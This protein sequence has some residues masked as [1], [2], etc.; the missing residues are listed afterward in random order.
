M[1]LSNKVQIMLIIAILFNLIFST[2]NYAL[3]TIV[4]ENQ[5]IISPILLIVAIVLFIIELFLPTFGIAGILSLL[6]F[7]GFFYL[8][9]KM[10]NADLLHIIIF[11]VGC[12][13][14][15]IEIFLPSFG[16]VGLSGI[17]LIVLGVFLASSDI[18]SGIVTLSIAVIVSTLLLFVFIKQGYKTRLFDSIIL[19][20]SKPEVKK[21]DEVPK[22]LVGME[23]VALTLLRPSGVMKIGDKRIDVV[24]RG[25]F[26]NEGE[27]L[28]IISVHGNIVKV[29]RR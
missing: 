22:D 8:N 10:G 18:M 23:G 11:L 21:V 29:R 1:K 4:V 12:L 16:I 2:F 15:G 20:D 14:L 17:A 7:I 5:Y 26:I 27:E 28:V 24:T 25:E 3:P 13:L 9:I 6:S 19:R